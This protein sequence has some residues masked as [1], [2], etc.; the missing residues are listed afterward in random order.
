MMTRSTILVCWPQSHKHTLVPLPVLQTNT[1][2]VHIATC[3]SINIGSVRLAERLAFLTSDNKV[4][5][6]NPARDG[7]QIMAVMHFI[8]QTLSKSPLHRFDMTSVGRINSLRRTT[9]T[10][11]TTERQ[12][13]QPSLPQRGD[14]NVR[15]LWPS[16]RQITDS[17]WGH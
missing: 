9:H 16:V 5:G 13:N 15:L 4:L 8:V 6:S 2:I 10:L 12:S 7:I 3:R 1:C 14:H 17:N 11:Q